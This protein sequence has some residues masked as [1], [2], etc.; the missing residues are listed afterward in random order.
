MRLK[1]LLLFSFVMHILSV[2]ISSVEYIKIREQKKSAYTFEPSFPFPFIHFQVLFQIENKS[3][4]IRNKIKTKYLWPNLEHYNLD[5]LCGGGGVV[6][7]GN[8]VDMVAGVWPGIG[9]SVWCCSSKLH[10]H[11]DRWWWRRQWWSS[12]EAV[13]VLGEK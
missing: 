1:P 5:H 6:V 13:A 8:I 12:D 9:N 11:C 2:S 7:I 10:S 4:D 3:L